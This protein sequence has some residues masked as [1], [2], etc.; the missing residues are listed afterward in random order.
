MVNHKYI[1]GIIALII[2]V[3][4]IMF[5]QPV[6]RPH[7]TVAPVS[8]FHPEALAIRDRLYAKSNEYNALE[9]RISE[10]QKELADIEV[11]KH[12]LSVAAAGYDAVLCTDYQLKYA[13]P[14]SV[15]LSG[16]LIKGC[17]ADF[18]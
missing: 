9:K 17:T 1:Y 16:A 5:A 3:C 14:T 18:Q 4:I 8:E 10:L 11:R 13:R 6:Y 15:A 12:S 2:A 7:P